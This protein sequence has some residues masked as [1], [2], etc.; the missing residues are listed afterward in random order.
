MLLLVAFIVSSCLVFTV[1]TALPLATYKQFSVYVRVCGCVNGC[2]S[3][4][5]IR[6]RTGVEFTL[7][8]ACI[9]TVDASA[10]ASRTPDDEGFLRRSPL[11]ILRPETVA[12]DPEG[13]RSSLLRKEEEKQHYLSRVSTDD[14]A[15]LFYISVRPSVRLFVALWYCIK[16]CRS[17][18]VVGPSRWF[19]VAEHFWSRC[20]TV[21][22]D[23][24]RRRKPD[25]QTCCDR[26]VE[27]LTGNGWLGR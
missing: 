7:I 15:I 20:S 17:W 11:V 26:D 5:C 14:S 19:P 6:V 1:Y 27:Q 22:G 24:F 18:G 10:V 21:Y 13:L 12:G 3:Q 2:G 23:K 16:G 4:Q 9:A 8:D 25:D